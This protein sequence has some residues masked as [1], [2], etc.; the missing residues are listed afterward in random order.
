M[1]T[2][3]PASELTGPCLVLLLTPKLLKGRQ[4]RQ[5]SW[6]AMGR[7]NIALLPLALVLILVNLPSSLSAPQ[8]VLNQISNWREFNSRIQVGDMWWWDG[9]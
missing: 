5:L 1:K 9:V 7:L 3:N 8:V 2:G 6:S 4:Y